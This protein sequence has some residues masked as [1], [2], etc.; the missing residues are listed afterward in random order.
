MDI[1]KLILGFIERQ[2]TQNSQFNIKG[3]KPSWKTDVI[4]L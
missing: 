4:H 2:K 3:E 1:E